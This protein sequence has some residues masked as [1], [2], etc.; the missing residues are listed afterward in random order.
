MENP[1]LRLNYSKNAVERASDFTEEK[2]V[3]KWLSL[4]NK[5]AC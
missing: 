3:E 5:T 2:I 4:F 1:E